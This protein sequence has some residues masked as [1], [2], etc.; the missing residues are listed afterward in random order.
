M[1]CGLGIRPELFDDVLGTKPKLGFIEAHS[2]NYF[3]DSIT[4]ARLLELR[5]HYAVSLH[6]VGLSLGRADALDVKHLAQL[7]KLADEIE[8]MFVSEH[9]AWSAYSHRHIP[10]LLPLPLTAQALQV[11]G[12]H[13][14]QMQQTLGRQI[15][16][17]NPSN[18]FVFDQ[19]QISEPDFLNQLAHN[20][21]CGLLV[22]VNNIYVSSANVGRDPEAYLHELNSEFIKQFHLAGYTQVERE[23]DGKTETLLIDTHNHPVYDPVWALYESALCQHGTR[24]TLFEW[25][26]DFPEFSVLMAECDKANILMASTS[27]ELVNSANGLMEDSAIE[28]STVEKSTVE[29]ASITVSEFSANHASNA[30]SNLDLEHLQRTFLDELLS[31]NE[32]TCFAVDGHQHRV[33]VYQNNAFGAL[34]DYLSEVFSAT[35]GV[36]GNAF[37]KQMAHVLVQNHPPKQGNVH[38]YGAELSHI[39]GCFE[40][41]ANMPYLEDLIRYEWALHAAYYSADS[42]PPSAFIDPSSVSQDELLNLVVELNSSVSLI[43]SD[44]PIYEIY[45]QSLPSFSDDIMINLNQSQDTL[46]VYKQ[47]YAVQTEILDPVKH[48]LIKQVNKSQNL[49]QAIEHLSGSIEMQ[50]LSNSLAFLFEKQLLNFK[51]SN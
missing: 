17:E 24:P 11:M 14:D 29:K 10:D 9:L 31:V 15:L 25:D 5:E 30:P 2:E 37:F 32:Q 27:N 1:R 4:R 34:L 47:Q 51:A 42:L 7:K 38:D 39:L 13:V 16:V 40:G 50:E 45:R 35:S 22:D 20:T 18:Y 36:V 23:L 21:G 49:L 44:F 12:E 6:G 8:P 26:S 41:L 43:D 3:G 19:L 46:L 28:K 33:G 48:Q